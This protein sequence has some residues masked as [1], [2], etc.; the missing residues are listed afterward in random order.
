[1]SRLV[2]ATTAEPANPEPV[3]LDFSSVQVATASY[4]RESVLAFRDL[5]RGRRSTFYPVIANA[6][7]DVRDELK[8]L[9]RLRGDVLMVC[10]LGPAGDVNMARLI[11]DLDPKQRMTFD[12]V[13]EHG[14]TDAGELM[15]AYG[16]SEGLKHTTAW[17]NRLAALAARGLLMEVSQG[18]AKRYRP[19]FEDA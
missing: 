13:H 12:L 5:V 3:F 1:M 15:R 14:E 2:E 18:R 6:N 11:G 9:M 10:T 8:E 4:L 7:D 17:N 19:L 16:E